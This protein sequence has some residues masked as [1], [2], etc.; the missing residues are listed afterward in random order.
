MRPTPIRM[1]LSYFFHCT[2]ISLHLA[3][4]IHLV[5]WVGAGS[6]VGEEQAKTDSLE[7]ASESTDGYGVSWALFG[8]DL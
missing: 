6:P 5:E 1:K 3:G 2:H 8:D 4:A 7:D